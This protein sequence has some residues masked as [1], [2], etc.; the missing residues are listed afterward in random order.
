LF[1]NFDKSS[2]ANWIDNPNPK[3]NFDF[4]LQSGLNN[5]AIRIEKSS[6]PMQQYPGVN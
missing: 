1:E 2:L 5:P 3:S 6:N 4:G